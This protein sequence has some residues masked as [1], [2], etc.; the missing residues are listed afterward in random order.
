MLSL[1]KRLNNL[2]P[3]FREADFLMTFLRRRFLDPGRFL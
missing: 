1:K 3:V 2:D